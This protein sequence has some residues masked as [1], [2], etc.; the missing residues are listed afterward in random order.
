MLF[1]MA[2]FRGSSSALV[3]LCRWDPVRFTT[4]LRAFVLLFLHTLT[5]LADPLS[6]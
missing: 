6:I 1:R 4:R 5:G 2:Q 3:L